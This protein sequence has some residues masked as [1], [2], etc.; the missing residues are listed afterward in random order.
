MKSIETGLNQQDDEDQR[1]R[2][3]D[4]LKKIW[5]KIDKMEDDAE[6]P[7]AEDELDKALSSLVELESDYGGDDHALSKEFEK[8]VALV[9]ERK[10]PKL[11]EQLASEMR[12]AGFSYLREQ[13]GFWVYL[14]EEAHKKFEET[15]WTNSTQARIAIDN[16]RNAV[17]EKPELTNLMEHYQ[18][19]ASY[20]EDPTIG[21]P[22][23]RDWKVL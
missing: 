11:A 22:G 10:D 18:E 14:I 9:K 1:E 17:R 13:P 2:A 4:S 23:R 3:K 16:A 19:I 5:A 12:S 6:W 7:R 20:F 15:E 8:Q 21:G